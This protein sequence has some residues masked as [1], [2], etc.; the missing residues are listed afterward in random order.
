VDDTTGS[1]IA[2]G[3]GLRT[4]SGWVY[5]DIDWD[6]PGG[7]LAIVTGPAGSGKTA[8]LLTLAARMQAG[9]GTLTVSGLDAVRHAGAVR[10]KAGLAEFRGVN[11]LDETLGVRDQ[12]MAEL[13]LHGKPWRGAHAGRVL[14]PLGLELDLHRKVR[15]LNAPDRLLLGVALGTISRPPILIV[16]ELDEDTTPDETALVLD[17]LRHLATSGTTV[18]AGALD[19]ALAVAADVSLALDADGAQNDSE[20]VLVHALV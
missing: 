20:E 6:V 1:I 4:R 18:I 13:A 14:E 7:S 19:P 5:R 11:D 12:L 10:R 15:D 8:L 9:Q 3:L 17:A 2:R 16:D